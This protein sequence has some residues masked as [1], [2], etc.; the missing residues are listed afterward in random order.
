[1]YPGW[2][3]RTH[4]P[5]WDLEGPPLLSPRSTC[6]FVCRLLHTSLQRPSPTSLPANVLSS[7]TFPPRP[8]RPPPACLRLQD[9]LAN[10]P[11]D[12]LLFLRN[13]DYSK[14]PREHMEAVLKFL[15]MSQPSDA[16]WQTVRRPAVGF[17]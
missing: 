10:W 1:M 7:P 6:K 9:W 5:G 12:Q 17:S 13:E 11:R 16:E 14:T 4:L 8:L 3:L 15:G 2:D